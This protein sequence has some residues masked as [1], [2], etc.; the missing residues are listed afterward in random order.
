MAVVPGDPT[1]EIW[2]EFRRIAEK[3]ERRGLRDEQLE[4]FEFYERGRRCYACVASGEKAQYA[5]IILKKGVV[6]E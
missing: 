6:R 3:Y 1:P 4:R 5:N 2:P